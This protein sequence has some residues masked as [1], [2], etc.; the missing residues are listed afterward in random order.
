MIITLLRPLRLLAALCLFTPAL[1]GQ[2]AFSEYVEG[3]AF[4]KAL[5]IYNYSQAPVDLARYRIEIYSAG[6]PTAT[7]TI[8]LD[9]Q[10]LA[11]QDVWVLAHPY[12][13]PT[14]LLQVDQLTDVLSF[15]G[16]DAIVLRAPWRIVDAIGE[17]GF[18]PGTEWGSGAEV[19]RDA[20]LHRTAYDC[21]I[22][23]VGIGSFD[24]AVAWSGTE[25]D[26]L[27]LLGVGPLHL[28]LNNCTFA[29][30]T[31]RNPSF[32]GRANP[33]A[34][35][36]SSLPVLGSTF[37]ATIDTAGRKGAYLVGF[38]SSL[39]RTTSWGNILV[40]YNEPPGEL[41]GMRWGTGNPVVISIDVP[42]SP[43]LV[44]LTICTQAVRFGDGVDL[45]NAQDLRFGY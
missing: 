3:S 12:I 5:E 20:T 32:W 13:D 30:A 17:I 18:D 40:D 42:S 45:T 37:T 29:S 38:Q 21:E 36:V 43:A 25:V 22:P 11:S 35:S 39:T 4:N 1:A 44:G 26:D 27:Y 10:S 2:L 6:S 7:S 16:D 28:S 19:T 8:E 33:S 15:D 9:P 31:Y 14:V 34:Y 41:L 24:P 23:Y